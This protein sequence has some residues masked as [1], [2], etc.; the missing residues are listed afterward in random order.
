[1]L[2]K[3][4]ENSINVFSTCNFLYVKYNQEIAVEESC[5]GG[6]DEVW[7]TK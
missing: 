1:M 5:A 6:Q 2:K 3:R 4:Q 7:K